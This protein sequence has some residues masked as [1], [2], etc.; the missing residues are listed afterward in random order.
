MG[1]EVLA[2]A[3]VGTKVA[4]VKVLLESHELILRGEIRRR[5]PRAEIEDVRVDGDRLR[6]TCAGE[7]VCLHLGSKV[8]EAWAKAIATPPPSLRA[9]LGLGKG[10]MAVLIGTCDD[11]ALIEALE[12]ALTGDLAKAAMIVA[13]IDGPED[14]AVAR[15]AQA[16]CPDLPV[17]AVYP[18]G[19]GVTYGD[20][21]IRA[22][23][24]DA[25]FRDTKS[26]AVSDRL[27]ATRYNPTRPKA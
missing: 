21:P 4:E 23:L 8:A 10:A 27:T 22:A 5:L 16:R 12:G 3:E 11:A 18:K 26:C 9:K 19:K 24:R 2:R 13:R 20:G 25:G 6:F 7:V 15:A 17:W 14:L 1:R